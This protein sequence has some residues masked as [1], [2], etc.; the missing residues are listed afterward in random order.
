ML[1]W[2][3]AH[4]R[5]RESPILN[6]L[7]VGGKAFLLCLLRLCVLHGPPPLVVYGIRV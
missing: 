2:H 3:C 7:S 1:C 6:V 4:F 5:G